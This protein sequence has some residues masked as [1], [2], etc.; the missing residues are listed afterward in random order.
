MKRC[1]ILNNLQV[2]L[3]THLQQLLLVMLQNC[4]VAFR[5]TVIGIL[6]QIIRPLDKKMLENI[7]LR[8]LREHI[9]EV[10]LVS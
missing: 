1:F 3:H 5:W 4:Y 9:C 6:F 10:R 2:V 8:A 7:T